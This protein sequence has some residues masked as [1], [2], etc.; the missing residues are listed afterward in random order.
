MLFGMGGQHQQHMGMYPVSQSQ[1]SYGQ[2]QTSQAVSQLLSSQPTSSAYHSAQLA[3][4]G[5]AGMP[6]TMLQGTQPNTVVLTS[7]QHLT[8]QQQ[9]MYQQQMQLQ[10]Q[11]QHLK[12]V[13]RNETSQLQQMRAKVVSFESYL[14]DA[15]FKC[16]FTTDSHFF[17][18][19][20]KLKCSIFYQKRQL[21]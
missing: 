1:L 14:K 17:A 4:S 20:G 8:P 3:S 13:R 16:F 10:H 21:T 9:Q 2:Q 12:K 15:P 5:L 19:Q 7:C 11:A 18:V 6:V